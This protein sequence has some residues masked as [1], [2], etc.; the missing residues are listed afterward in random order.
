MCHSYAWNDII[1]NFKSNIL[2]AKRFGNVQTKI[3]S[4]NWPKRIA[5]DLKTY[6]LMKDIYVYNRGRTYNNVP[7]TSDC[8]NK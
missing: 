1:E 8:M 3:C 5:S 4:T 7:F 6:S 2:N